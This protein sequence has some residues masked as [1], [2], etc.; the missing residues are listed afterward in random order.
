MQ[1]SASEFYYN[2]ILC[3]NYARTDVDFKAGTEW[4]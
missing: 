2:E 1:G 3:E 4:H